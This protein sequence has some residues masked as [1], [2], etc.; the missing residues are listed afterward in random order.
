MGRSANDISKASRLDLLAAI[1]LSWN[2]K[3]EEGDR[4]IGKIL[5]KVR[6]LLGFLNASL[7]LQ[8]KTG[9]EVNCGKFWVAR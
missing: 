2:D 3:P 9:E 4:T 6:G 8:T 5:D 1:I 7:H